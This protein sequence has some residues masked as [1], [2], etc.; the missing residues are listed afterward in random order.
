MTRISISVWIY[1]AEFETVFDLLHFTHSFLD[2]LL[3]IL[4]SLLHLDLHRVKQKFN[5]GVVIFTQY[6]TF[7]FHSLQTCK[8]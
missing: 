3:K 5:F 1:L 4:H 8:I 2:H 7:L 6:D